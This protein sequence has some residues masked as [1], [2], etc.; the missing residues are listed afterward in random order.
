MLP[1]SE[2]EILSQEITHEDGHYRL[3]TRPE[4]PLPND[5]GRH[6]RL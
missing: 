2:M 1:K 5:L 6:I 4:S 3:R